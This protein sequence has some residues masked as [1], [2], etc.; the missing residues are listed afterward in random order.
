MYHMKTGMKSL[1]PCHYSGSSWTI[2][3]LKLKLELE[4][5]EVV[6]NSRPEN[7]SFSK[8][9]LSNLLVLYRLLVPVGQGYDKAE[10]CGPVGQACTADRHDAI[11]GMGCADRS[12][13]GE[14]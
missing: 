10:P 3:I 11:G 12:G 7:E 1:K 6:L 5:S 4:C 2:I 9:P 13:K 8:I 14:D